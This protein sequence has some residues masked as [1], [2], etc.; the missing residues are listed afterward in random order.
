M[1]LKSIE[2]IILPYFYIIKMLSPIELEQIKK[3]NEYMKMQKMIY[4]QE[5]QKEGFCQKL[6]RWICCKKKELD[7]S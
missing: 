4:F 7:L 2:R 6:K 3:Y 1:I 5:E